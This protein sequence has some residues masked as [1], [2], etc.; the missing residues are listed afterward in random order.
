MG[1]LIEV[2]PQPAKAFV[3][4]GVGLG[5]KVAHEVT[6]QAAGK[7]PDDN[8]TAVIAKLVPSEVIAGY[9]SVLGLTES[10]AKEPDTQFNL[11]FWSLWVG[12]ALTPIYLWL[13]GNP[14]K[15]Y[16]WVSIVVATVAFAL[17]AYLLGG[18]FVMRQMDHTWLGSYLPA[19]DKR[20]A[21]F[22]VGVFTWV[23][24]GI[25]SAAA[26]R[27]PGNATGSA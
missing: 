26:R 5:E 27:F 4:T 8:V 10:F 11:Q 1:R 12:L 7:S 2:R 20:Y 6:A 22:A 15:W 16:Q 19:Y 3:P 23:V 21:S 24:G 17:W 9:V 25:M 14:R 13:W 18:P